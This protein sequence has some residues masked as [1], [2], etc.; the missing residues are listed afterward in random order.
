[1]F[2]ASVSVKGVTMAAVDLAQVQRI[3]MARKANKPASAWE[4]ERIVTSIFALLYS[5]VPILVSK[6]ARYFASKFVLH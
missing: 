4:A 3:T 5:T 2:A 1:M 6:V